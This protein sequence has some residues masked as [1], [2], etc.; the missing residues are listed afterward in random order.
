MKFH[1]YYVYILTNAYHDVLYT[2][3]T[4]DLERRCYE[5]KYKKI[6]GFTQKYNVD[7]LVYFEIFE[8]IDSAIQREKQIK[9]YS[10]VKKVALINQYNSEWKDLYC[11]GKIESPDLQSE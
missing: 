4:N 1:L 7:T 3:V 9:G 5:H 8:S 11:D 10:R 6:K 2:G